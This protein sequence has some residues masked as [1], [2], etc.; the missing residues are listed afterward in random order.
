VV[1]I[2]LIV[3]SVGIPLELGARMAAN[4]AAVV[5]ALRSI[6]TAMVLYQSA[7][8]QGYP[9]S[10]AALGPANGAP[11][12]VSHADIVDSVLAS[13]TRS[14]YSFVYAPSDP[15]DAGQYQSYT[16]HASPL[17]PGL[18]GR[19]YFYLDQTAILRF[20]PGGPADATSDTVPK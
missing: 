13:G 3:A 8:Q 16:V 15:S 4:E 7:Y 6:S 17:K 14:G 18:T 20:K 11:A 19:N 1:A 12:S 5:S 2:I 10:L 9:S